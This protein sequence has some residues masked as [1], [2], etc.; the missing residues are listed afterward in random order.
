[1]LVHCE[2][3]IECG[4]EQCVHYEEHEYDE[5]ESLLPNGALVISPCDVSR[6]AMMSAKIG[7]TNCGCVSVGDEEDIE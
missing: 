6:C 1:M 4:N 2:L 7:D 5:A 3:R